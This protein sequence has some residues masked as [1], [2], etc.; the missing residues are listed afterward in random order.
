MP[1]WTIH[2]LYVN[3]V[4]PGSTFPISSPGT[5]VPCVNL[6]ILTQLINKYENAYILYRGQP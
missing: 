4:M 3:H 1:T 6:K 5:T 2:G